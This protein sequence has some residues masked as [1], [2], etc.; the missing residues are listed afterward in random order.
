M[1]RVSVDPAADRDKVEEQVVKLLSDDQRNPK[2]ATGAEFKQALDNEQWR[3]KERIDELSAIEFRTLGLRRV[4][5]FAEDEKLDEDTTEKLIKIVEEEWDR[6]MNEVFPNKQK[7]T[8]K[9]DW[10][11]RCGQ[12]AA[13]VV[14]R[15]KS[16]L[17]A[18]QVERLKRSLD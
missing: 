10:A 16:L 5:T 13:A 8:G 14:E 3:K 9:T 15:A 4:R 6:L 12:C 11:A 2:R 18:E 7:E 1:V 17:T